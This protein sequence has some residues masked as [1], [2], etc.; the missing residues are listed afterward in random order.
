[1]AVCDEQWVTFVFSTG[2]IPAHP[3]PT[4]MVY[5]EW[6]KAANRSSAQL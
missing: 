3:G 5:N 1:M 2:V 6:P 4:G